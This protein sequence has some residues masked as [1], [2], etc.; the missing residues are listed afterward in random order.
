VENKKVV[1]FVGR[2]SKVKGPDVLIKAMQRVAKSW[3]DAVL[4]VVGGKW[5]TDRMDDEYGRSLQQLA[6]KLKGRVF[7]TGFVPP[8]KI[9][10]T[11]LAGDVFV[12]SSQWEEPLARVH[13]EAMGAGLPVI[14]TNRGGNAEIVKHGVNGLVINDYNNPRA[15][16]EAISRL[17]ANPEEAARFAREGR[18]LMERNHGFEHAA[19]RLERLYMEARRR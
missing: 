13:Y 15:F 6:K 9:P 14:T 10:T 17:F 19:E 12:C 2:I 8:K 18:A 3:P 11:Y 1:L 5:F 4:L 16:A 7:F